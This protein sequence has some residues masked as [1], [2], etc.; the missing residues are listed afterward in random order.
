MKKNLCFVCRDLQRNILPE[1]WERPNVRSCS[2]C[3]SPRECSQESRECQR[4]KRATGVQ[5]CMR[6][7]LRTMQMEG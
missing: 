4:E 3:E 7:P 6:G 1:N 2:P 5:K